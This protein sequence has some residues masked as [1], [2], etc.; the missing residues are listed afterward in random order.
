MRLRLTHHIVIVESL[1]PRPNK[2]GCAHQRGGTGANFA[3]LGDGLGKGG[4]VEEDLL[5]KSAECLAN[6][7]LG[8]LDELDSCTLDGESPWLQQLSQRTVIIRI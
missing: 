7:P 3:D 2:V 4:S 8:Y 1:A 6:T 5:V